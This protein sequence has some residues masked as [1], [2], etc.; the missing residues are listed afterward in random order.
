MMTKRDPYVNML[1]TTIAVAAAGLGG[2]DAITV[3]PHTAPLGLPDAFARRVARNTQLVLLEESNLARV[4]DPAAGSGALEALTR[5][6]APPLGRCSRRSK[7]RRRL[8]GVGNRPDSAPSRRG[9]RRAR[10]RHRPPQGYS[11]R[12]QRISRTSPRL[13]PRFSMSRRRR[14]RKTRRRS[15]PR[16]CRAS[17][18]P[19]RSNSCA[20]PRTKFWPQQARGRKCFWPRSASPPTSTPAPT[21]PRIFSRPAA[22]K[23]SAAETTPPRSSRRSKRRARPSPACAGRTRP[24]TARRSRRRR[25]QGSRRATG[26]SGRTARRDGRHLAGGGRADLHLRGLRCPGDTAGGLRYSK[27]KVNR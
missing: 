15:P 9:A 21:S 7:R 11:D 8:G 23:R 26:L 4:A 24:T 10:T 19:S 17:G 1:R 3:L 27:V 12:H 20:T 13:R 16:H 14:C 25:A 22:S 6:S 2:A 18:S 5:S